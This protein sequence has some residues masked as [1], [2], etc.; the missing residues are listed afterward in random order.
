MVSSSLQPKANAS[1]L[2]Q[3]KS[4][5]HLTVAEE[6]RLALQRVHKQEQEL[7]TMSQKLQK[8]EK[9]LDELR[10][11]FNQNL[12]SQKKQE[13]DA[14]SHA[15]ILSSTER[16][17]ALVVKNLSASRQE[18][19]ACK[20]DLFNLQPSHQVPDTNIVQDFDSVCGKIIEWVEDEIS[21]FEKANPQTPTEHFFSHAGNNN[22]ETLL[23]E[24][25][26]SGEYLV[27]YEIH[28]FL[29][30][31]MFGRP[32]YL[33]GLPAGITEVLRKAEQIMATM[34]PPRGK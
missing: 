22:A 21:I 15:A 16:K 18:M 20:D 23:L 30:Q 5:A 28:N 29:Q 24:Y 10:E 7:S 13:A 31:E 12:R 26:E 25:P 9:N 34:D 11:C 27:R 4:N 1:V 3:H 2:V 32:I 17:Y 8:S 14:K 19:Q 33:L 6:L